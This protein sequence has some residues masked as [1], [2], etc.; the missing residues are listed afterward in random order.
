MCYILQKNSVLYKRIIGNF[1]DL[2]INNYN[3]IFD[4]REE[5]NLVCKKI[6]H[7]KDCD[8]FNGSES[9]IQ[10]M[11]IGDLLCIRLLDCSFRE[12]E[13]IRYLISA[14]KNEFNIV[15]LL[16]NKEYQ[17]MYSKNYQ[18]FVCLLEFDR[19][20]NHIIVSE[21]SFK[22]NLDKISNVNLLICDLSWASKFFIENKRLIIDSSCEIIESDRN[23]ICESVIS[24][25][26]FI[27][28]LKNYME[29]IDNPFI[30][31]EPCEGFDTD[32]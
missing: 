28:E 18:T 16:L 21:E 20:I 24:V 32:I 29:K 31:N 11:R 6:R 1:C 9:R 7:S 30:R 14:C 15:I 5:L 3:F 8:I 27:G 12:L 25:G 19:K 4:V 26:S 22:L 23:S 2:D 13:L 17:W 10:L